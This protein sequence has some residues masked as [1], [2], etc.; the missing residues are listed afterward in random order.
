MDKFVCSAGKHCKDC[1]MDSLGDPICQAKHYN[2]NCIKHKGNDAVDEFD[3]AD[4][5]SVDEFDDVGLTDEVEDWLM[6]WKRD[7]ALLRSLDK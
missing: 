7:E 5:K 4:E 2:F 3:D 6:D 1:T